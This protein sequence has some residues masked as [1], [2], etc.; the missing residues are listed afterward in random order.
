MSHGS[1]TESSLDDLRRRIDRLDE[2]IVRML[3]ER[4]EVVVEIGRLKQDGQTPIYAPD[5]EQRV[6]QRIREHNHGPLPDACLEGMWRELMSGSFALERPLRIGY[7]GPPGSFSHLAATRQ[8]GS[9]VDYQPFESISSVFH[10]VESRRID[11]GLVPVEN[12]IGGGIHESLDNFLQSSVHVCAEVMIPIHHNLL[13][14]AQPDQIRRI[15][16]RPEIFEQC[17]RWL[18]EHFRSAERTASSSSAR[19]AEVASAEEGAAAIGSQLAAEIYD[20]P[21]LHESIED[22][23]NNVTR[24]FVIGQ[25]SS[26]PSGDDKTA[27][28]FTT[29]H[30]P[31]ALAQ[32]IDAFSAK[33]VNLTHIDKRPSQRVNWEYSFFIDCDGHAENPEVAAAIAEARQH[34]LQLTILGSF[35]RAATV[36]H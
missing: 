29:E 24:F 28:L 7:L 9:C 34:C 14:R 21:I 11:L 27:I 25:Q 13:S 10:G 26:R 33:G 35:P 20:L 6:L 2:Q 15:Y 31:G 17:R 19:A 32:V 1:Q 16:S 5:R 18:A 12:T 3:N 36:V 23:P 22:N 8:F 4:A 30:K